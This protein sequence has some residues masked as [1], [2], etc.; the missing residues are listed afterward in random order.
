M[1]RSILQAIPGQQ[2]IAKWPQFAPAAAQ[3]GDVRWIGGCH[4]RKRSR[5]RFFRPSVSSGRPFRDVHAARLPPVPTASQ[6]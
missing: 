2:P 4:F 5:S 1:E 3:F 6:P